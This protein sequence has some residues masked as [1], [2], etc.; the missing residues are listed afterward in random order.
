MKTSIRARLTGTLILGTGVLM[1]ASVSALYVLVERVLLAQF[2]Q[3]LLTKTR[4]L[5]LF[6]EADHDGINLEFTEHPLPE[7]ER[8]EMGEYYQLWLRDGTVL[9]KSSSLGGTDLQPQYG[10]VEKPIFQ[11]IRL[12]NGHPG[13]AVGIGFLPSLEDDDSAAIAHG[14]TRFAMGLVVARD[15]TSLDRLLAEV[16]FGILAAG[17]LLLALTGWLVNR[18]LRK[19]LA[20]ING[21]VHEVEALEAGSLT[22]A[23][24]TTDDLPGELVPIATELNLLIGRLNEAFQRERRLT[25]DIAHEINTPLSELRTA[26]EVALKWPDDPEV[27]RTLAQQTLETVTNLQNVTGELLELARQQHAAAT[28][29]QAVNLSAL[30]EEVRTLYTSLAL[31]R[32][33]ILDE[34]IAVDIVINSNPVLLRMLLSNLLENALEYSPP[35]ATI[36]CTLSSHQEGSWQFSIENPN[37]AL[38]EADLKHLFDPLWRHDAARTASKHCGLGL[39]LVQTV[40]TRLEITIQA[41]LPSPETFRIVLESSST[42]E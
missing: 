22:E 26:S 14:G 34:H 2:D 7:F 13:R 19:G 4:L 38:S 3:S 18:A 9:S 39:S 31:K 15:R 28:D 20:P 21:L 41:C 42:P 6:P 8:P 24:I 10:A 23:K 36:H 25:S 37:T 32:K 30:W 11:N 17:G 5:T 12:P 16:R 29:S 35:G 27:T 33:L 40:A 1:L